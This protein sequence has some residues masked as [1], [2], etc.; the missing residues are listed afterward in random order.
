MPAIQPCANIVQNRQELHQF[1]S[2]FQHQYVATNQRKILSLAWEIPWIDPLVVLQEFSRPHQLHF[3]FEK[4]D[5]TEAIAA[6]GSVVDATAYGI[7]RFSQ[8]QDFIQSCLSQTVILSLPNLPVSGPHFF[9]S[10]TFFN[11]TTDSD[12]YFPPATIFLP[13]IQIIRRQ[14]CCYLLMNR[15]LE[16]DQNLPDISEEICQQ[17]QQILNLQDRGI[18]PRHSFSPKLSIEP[19]SSQRNFKT[20]VFS[21]LKLIEENQFNKVV[22]AQAFDLF[23]PQ[24][25]DGIHSLNNLRNFY[26]DCYIF[27]TSNSRGQQFIGASPERLISIHKNQFVT[28]A[29]AGSAPRGKTVREDRILASRL[30]Q[31]EKDLREHQVVIDFIKKRLSYLG[32]RPHFPSVPCLLKLSNIQHLWTPIQAEI[33]SN[34]HLLDILAELHPTPAVAGAPRDI[35]QAK[36]RDYEMFDRSL[37]A[38]PLGWIDHQGNGEFAVAIRSALIDGNRAR[39]YAGAGIVAG[40]KPDKELAEIQLKLQAILNALVSEI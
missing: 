12:G 23:S 17:F 5:T 20:S 33:N 24:K 10:F 14:K 38:A 15:F 28:D 13:K 11:E 30:L 37:Y 35:A 9:C 31:S 4:R 40:S 2:D 7:S 29:L 36:I 27:S 19:V 34:I 18:S 3:Y 8:F 32:L 21:A 22:L 25:F 16:I 39:L 1:L 6:I 26:P